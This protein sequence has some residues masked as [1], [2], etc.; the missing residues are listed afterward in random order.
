MNIQKMRYKKQAK[1]EDFSENEDVN[2]API[3]KFVH[4]ILESS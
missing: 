2:A 1:N 4:N 3:V